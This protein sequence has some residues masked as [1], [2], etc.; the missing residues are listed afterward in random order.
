MA[1]TQL[2]EDQSET[3]SSRRGAGAL[4]KAR[5]RTLSAYETARDRTRETARDVT[6]QIAVYPLAAV[7]GG[8]AIG[9]LLAFILPRTQGET[10]LLGA[11]GRKLN[12]AARDAAQRGVDFGREK[13]DA[14]AG[15]AASKVSSAVVEAV[16][17]K[18]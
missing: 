5:E 16:V 2:V 7:A 14:L 10:R 6:G 3:A 4:G 9:A 18:D 1:E 8:L 15:K 11:T 17:A 13:V 12:A